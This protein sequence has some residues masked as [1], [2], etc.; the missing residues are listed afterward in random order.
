[1]KK[2]FLSAFIIAGML[3][4]SRAALP[5]NGDEFKINT[6]ASK[7]EWTGR[8]VTGKHSGTIGVKSGSLTMKDGMLVGGTITIDMFSIAVTDLQGEGAAKLERHLKSD[9]FFG[10]EKFPTATLIVKESI[11]KGKGEFEVKGDLTIKG[12]TQPVTFTTHIKP[13]GKKYTANSNITIDRSLFDVRYGSGKFF[14]GLGDKTI[15]DVF[16]LAISL[17]TE[18]TSV[19]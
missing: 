6:A 1:M 19:R 12:I 13:D 18:E 2:L 4:A 7:I 11:A 3:T 16:D 10:V 9:D 8:K 15:Y 14:E 5:T 17:V